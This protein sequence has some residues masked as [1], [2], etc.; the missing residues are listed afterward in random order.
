MPSPPPV[1][2]NDKCR[3]TFPPLYPLRMLGGC[4]WVPLSHLGGSRPRERGYGRDIHP[5]SG[6]DVGIAILLP[7]LSVEGLFQRLPLP[8]HVFSK[9]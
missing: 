4:G 7:S 9:H 5:K 6:P 3:D 1:L 2:P 8:A